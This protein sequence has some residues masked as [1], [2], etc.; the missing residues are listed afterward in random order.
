MTWGWKF[1]SKRVWPKQVNPFSALSRNYMTST[2]APTLKCSGYLPGFHAWG[3]RES[4]GVQ[5]K[6]GSAEPGREIFLF[7]GVQFRL[8]G[9]TPMGG[10]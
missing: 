6:S 2:I 8:G 4:M 3:V 5:T 10:L 9:V 1:G 7:R